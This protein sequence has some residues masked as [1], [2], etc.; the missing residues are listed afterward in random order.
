M[1]SKKETLHSPGPIFYTNEIK[2]SLPQVPGGIV[3]SE[4][5]RLGPLN[6]GR[7]RW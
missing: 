2:V 4:P 7:A 3:L 6:S 5:S 1:L